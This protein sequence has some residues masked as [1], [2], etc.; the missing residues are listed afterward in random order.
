MNTRSVLAL[1]VVVVGATDSASAYAIGRCQQH[2]STDLRDE[3]DM[4]YCDGR[5]GQTTF[6]GPMSS[7]ADA[8]RD[9]GCGPWRCTP[10]FERCKQGETIVCR[11]G[12]G[13]V[14]THIC[15]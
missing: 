15:G 12:C 3:D 7:G 2:M 14:E 11:D 5:A 13:N 10:R 1:V 9:G 4:F 6:E 8:G